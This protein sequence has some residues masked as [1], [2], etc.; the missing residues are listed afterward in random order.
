MAGSQA[1]LVALTKLIEHGCRLITKYRAQ[2]QALID[3][4]V[5]IGSITAAQGATLEAWL[6]AL[7]GICAILRLVTRY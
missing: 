7:S 5:S 2:M 4:A 6:D 1:G 3:H